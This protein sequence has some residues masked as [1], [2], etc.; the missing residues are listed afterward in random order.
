MNQREVTHGNSLQTSDAFQ[1]HIEKMQIRKRKCQA[2]GKTSSVV[3]QSNYSSF[4]GS[5]LDCHALKIRNKLQVCIVE[6]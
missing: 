3:E 4:S 5:L 2:Q 1:K 6:F